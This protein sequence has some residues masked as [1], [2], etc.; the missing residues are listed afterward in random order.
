MFFGTDDQ[1]IDYA[2]RSLPLAA[3]QGVLLELWTAEGAGHGFF[4]KAPWFEWTLYLT[5]QF[6]QKNGYLEGE[7]GF[8]PPGEVTM[9]LY[10][11]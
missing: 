2:Y 1:L 10:K 5:D 3:S 8:K 9:E 4:N 11:Q 7:A 6:L